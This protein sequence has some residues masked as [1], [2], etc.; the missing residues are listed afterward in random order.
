M[1][2]AIVPAAG[3]S[4]R[5]GRAKLIL[6]WGRST[7]AGAVLAALRDAG[8]HPVVLVVAPPGEGPQPGEL[9]GAGE[10]GPAVIV[11]VNP[12]PGRGMLSS[13][14]V[15]LAALGG[16]AELARRGET[17]LVTPADLPALRA[18]TV[19]ALI[20]AA[21]GA[22][23]QGPA[24]ETPRSGLGAA[25]GAFPEAPAAETLR[26]RPT[27]LLALPVHRGRRGH[28]LLIAPAL[29]AEIATLDPGRGLR[30]LRDR[31]MA[32]TLE[33]PVDDPGCVA[34][35]DT[36]EDYARLAAAPS[37]SPPRPE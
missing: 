21:A 17:V 11:A 27:A 9:A 2:A 5:M 15:G 28:P 7:V 19:R 29:L 16:A 31:H 8:V 24:G 18:E 35:L 34:D 14:Q 22:F 20:A 25:A 13:I 6:P 4:R 32:A 1:A 37:T 36:P 10:A 33:L 12:E 23:P 30:E 26:S 3:A